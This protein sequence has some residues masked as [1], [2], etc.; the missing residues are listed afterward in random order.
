MRAVVQ[1]VRQSSVYVDGQVVGEIRHGLLVLLGVAEGDSDAD[2][3]YLSAKV[4]RL[5]LFDDNSGKMNL[6]VLDV[7]GSALVVS[8]FTLLGDVRRGL[9]PSFT[10]AAEPQIANE[11]YQNFCLKLEK[12]GLKVERG[13]FQAEM[14]VSLINDGPVTILLD[15]KKLF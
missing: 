13:V 8:Q 6:D 11:L 4:A 1:R 10:D 9:R 2:A 3:E 7:G 12:Q 14:Q 5:R 15:S